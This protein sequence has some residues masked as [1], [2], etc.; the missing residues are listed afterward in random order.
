MR[1]RSS[2]RSGARSAEQQLR[3]GRLRAA[4]D[5][6]IREEACFSSSSIQPTAPSKV[7]T[8]L[9]T[10]QPADLKVES[11][12][13]PPSELPPRG[14]RIV[15]RRDNALVVVADRGKDASLTMRPVHSP[16]TGGIRERGWVASSNRRFGR[17][18]PDS[19]LARRQIAERAPGSTLAMTF[20][21]PAWLVDDADSAGL[22]IAEKGA[23]AAGTAFIRFSTPDERLALARD[24]GIHRTRYV[25]GAS[26]AGLRPSSGGDLLVA[27]ISPIELNARRGSG[28]A[29]RGASAEPRRVPSAGR[30]RRRTG[31]RPCRVAPGRC[32]GRARR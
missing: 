3:R 10:Y 31:A 22:Q 2:A 12:T 4:A 1:N 28:C 5:R 15:H 29:W 7:R 27:T 17:V 24:A 9:R 19:R 26:L 21:L 11:S 30:R 16:C 14:P 8:A 18:A 13:P 6:H 23:R 25:A 32:R 20:L